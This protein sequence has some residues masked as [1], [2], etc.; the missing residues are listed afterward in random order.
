[1]RILSPTNDTRLLCVYPFRCHRHL[2]RQST[3][4]LAAKGIWNLVSRMS[5][6]KPFVQECLSVG[7]VGGLCGAAKGA[8]DLLLALEEVGEATIASELLLQYPHELRVDERDC[9]PS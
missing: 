1:M 8:A 3:S 7:V 6:D 9:F 4:M 5:Q 2:R